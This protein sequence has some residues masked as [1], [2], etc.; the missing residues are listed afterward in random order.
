MPTI[1]TISDDAHFKSCCA[2]DFAAYIPADDTRCRRQSPPGR[3]GIKA[4]A[5]CFIALEEE[6]ERGIRL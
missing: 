3:D 5:Q 6:S 4:S 1:S 2:D